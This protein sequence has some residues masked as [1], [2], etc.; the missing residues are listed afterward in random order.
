[1]SNRRTVDVVA[2]RGA[3]ADHAENSV[4]AFRGAREQGAD[5]VELDVRLAL[6]GSL[7]V[8]HDAT[9]AD[10]RAVAATAAEDRPDGVPLLHVALEACAGMGVNVEIKNTPGDLGAGVSHDLRVADLTVEV[11]AARDGGADAQ[12]ILV[13]S[14]DEATLERVRASGAGLETGLLAWDL[15]A[16]A[17]A[18]DRAVAAG[19][20]AI[21]P[22]DPFVDEEFMARC[23]DLGLRVTA[24]P[25]DDPERI[26][27]LAERGAHGIITNVPA[28]ARRTLAARRDRE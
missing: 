27:R 3:S 2:H 12:P 22:W 4:E 10:G 1:M 11:L 26:T 25:V 14:F 7:V 16:D 18:L 24:W 23:A 28:G 9:Y 17:A 13:T 21:N 19:H 5:W 15:H 6:D 8:H 20:T